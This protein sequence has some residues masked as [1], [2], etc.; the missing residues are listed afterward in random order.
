MLSLDLNPDIKPQRT[1]VKKY[2]QKCGFVGDF[3][4][5][6]CQKIAS[7][8]ILSVKVSKYVVLDETMSVARSVVSDVIV[9]E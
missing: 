5:C 7:Q 4:D 8:Q 9:R 3:W 1:P 2:Y 6:L